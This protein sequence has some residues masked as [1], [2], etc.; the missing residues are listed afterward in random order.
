ML[1]MALLLP[2]GHHGGLGGGAG[3]AD[4]P[5]EGVLTPLTAPDGSRRGLEAGELAHLL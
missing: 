4:G 3:A 1:A 5:G 2:G